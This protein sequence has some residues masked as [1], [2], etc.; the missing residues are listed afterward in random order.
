MNNFVRR[1]GLKRLTGLTTLEINELEAAENFPKPFK[2]DGSDFW[3]EADF[4]RQVTPEELAEN[5]R[6]LAQGWKM[7]ADCYANALAR[8]R[9]VA[10][11]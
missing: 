8:G 11:A 10:E 2:I 1:R 4:I 5:E 7:A 9:N 3:W 6:T